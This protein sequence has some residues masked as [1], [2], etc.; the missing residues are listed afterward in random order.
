MGDNGARMLAKAL[1]LNTKL[2]AVYW[3][4]NTTTSQ[5]FHDVALAL[6]K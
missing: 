1:Q 6:E 5:G 3:D 4:R 2:S